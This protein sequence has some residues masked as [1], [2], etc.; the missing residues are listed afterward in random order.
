MSVGD[1]SQ[2]GVNSYLAFIRETTWGTNPNTAG[3]GATAMEFL[4]CS[5]KTSFDHEKL[6]TLGFRGMTKRV[7]KNKVVQG[8][9]ESYLNPE[10]TPLLI[11]AAMGAGINNASISAGWSHSMT[12]GN[13]VNASISGA[14][15][16]GLTLVERKGDIVYNYVGGRIN[17]LKI[18]ANVNEVAKVSADFIFKDATIGAT[19]IGSTLTYTAAL[20]FTFVNG[21]YRY[22][23]TEATADTTTAEEPITGFELNINNNLVSDDSARKLG[24]NLLAVLPATRREVMLKVTQRFDTTTTYNRMVQGTQGAVTLVFTGATI[25]TASTEPYYMEIRLPKVFHAAGNDPEVG[26]SGEIIMADIEFDCLMDSAG[27]AGREIGMTV[28]NTTNY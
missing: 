17:S 26:G 15:F 9:V 14:A 6:D 4:A 19:D 13:I 22:Q 27:S 7:M 5:F 25:T 21:V 10:E 24:S 23:T 11:A 3:T 28:K 20:P 12:V 2:Q 1:S 18:T 8:N 16:A